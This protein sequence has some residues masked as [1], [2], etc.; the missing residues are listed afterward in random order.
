VLNFNGHDPAGKAAVDSQTLCINLA[1][2][3]LSVL[4]VEWF[5]SGQLAASGFA[6]GRLNQLDLT[7]TSGVGPFYLAMSRALDLLLAQPGVDPQ[8]VG[9]VGFDGGGWQA[10]LLGALDTRVR[11]VNPVAGYAS[12]YTSLRN[13][14]DL[15]D[16]EYLPYDLCTVGDYLH[17]TVLLS[18]RP[19]LLTYNAKDPCCFD[20][21]RTLSALVGIAGPYYKLADAERN[22][23]WFNNEHNGAHAFDRLN[24]E[25]FYRVLGENF[26]AENKNWSSQELEC[27]AELRTAEELSVPLPAVNETFHSLAEKLA[28]KLPREPDIPGRASRLARWQDQQRVA[29]RDLVRAKEYPV[30]A[31][32][33]MREEAGGLTAVQWRLH[34][35]SDWTVP[36]T[37][38]AR[39]TPKAA[40]LVVADQ[41]RKSAAVEIEQL[42]NS[43]LRVLAVDPF[44][45]GES[46]PTKGEDAY[47]LLIA[48]LGDRP[49][50]VQASQVAAMARWAEAK[51]RN[52]PLVV[53]ALGPRTSLISLV[54]AG[55][56]ENAIGGLE[57]HGA[58][59][60][61]K[62]IIKADWTMEQAPEAFCPGLLEQF[63][64]PKLEGLVKPRPLVRRAGN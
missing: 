50:G 63:D 47:P 17:F 30:E 38:L 46:R 10:L 59:V 37:E 51:F 48:A 33:V 29:L 34:F 41:G 57:L 43:G 44:G 56:E 39:G 62:D 36:A 21:D 19:L 49:L 13:P 58:W 52:G 11:L 22:L 27:T 42:L 60:S 2:R 9:A 54:A 40:A 18:P 28:A 15:H 8:R 64:V 61:L 6:H 35:G 53:V 7:G 23:S 5:G 25:R 32:S 4:N 20:A 31:E 45:F 12:L 24:R 1:K 55:V 16:S 26:L 3:G 14:E